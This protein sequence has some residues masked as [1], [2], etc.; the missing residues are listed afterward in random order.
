MG[1][2]LDEKYNQTLTGLQYFAECLMLSVVSLAAAVDPGSAWQA[3]YICLQ[4]L[5]FVT[6]DFVT[7]ETSGP[8]FDTCLVKQRIELSA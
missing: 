3:N 4:T 8:E 7:L 2:K 6:L 1:Y 5:D